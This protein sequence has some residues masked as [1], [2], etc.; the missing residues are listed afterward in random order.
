MTTLRRFLDAL[1]LDQQTYAALYSDPSVPTGPA[2]PE[3]LLPLKGTAGTDSRDTAR[4]MISGGKRSAR[5]LAL[6]RVLTEE[7]IPRTVVITADPRLANDLRVTGVQ[8][9]AGYDPILHKPP[10]L[11]AGILQK[12]ALAAG[13]SIPEAGFAISA[14]LNELQNTGEL[15]FERFVMN[16]CASLSSRAFQSG[17]TDAAAAQ[18]V[19]GARQLDSYRQSFIRNFPSSGSRPRSLQSLLTGTDPL[20]FYA[21]SAEE[22]FLVLEDL[23]GELRAG[24]VGAVVLDE[25]CSVLTQKAL[26]ELSLFFCPVILSDADLPARGIFSAACVGLTA[27]LFF[28]H[29]SGAAK[30]SEFFGTVKRPQVTTTANY[31][32]A[33]SEWGGGP[34]GIFGNTTVSSGTSTST[35]LI[36]EPRV[37]SAKISALPAGEAYLYNS[38]RL[39]RCHV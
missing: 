21:P 13:Y 6:Q 20:V 4:Y 17:R 34:F 33:D 39:Y 18:T 36:T 14:S 12:A 15:S 7:P 5:V 3:Q 1:F 19:P 11:A 25:V 38:G 9:G 2:L 23:K 24:H 26:D 32:T 29:Q 28:N 22:I 16:G 27:G 35:V 31:G 8:L 37:T 30:L 10:M